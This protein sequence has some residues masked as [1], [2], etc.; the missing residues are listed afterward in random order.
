MVIRIIMK[1]YTN[2]S[3]GTKQKMNILARQAKPSLHREDNCGL[4]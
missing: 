4:S 1:S 2:Y 3:Y